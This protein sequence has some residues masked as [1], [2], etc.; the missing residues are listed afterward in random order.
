M[1]VT[2]ASSPHNSSPGGSIFTASE[3]SVSIRGILNKVLEKPKSLKKQ[4]S[5]AFL[6][7]CKVDKK[8]AETLTQAAPNV[9]A[10]TVSAHYQALLEKEVVEKE[11]LDE[12]TYIKQIDQ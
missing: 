10:D 2:G 5:G 3:T 1:Q 6:Y 11:A 12:G 7:G 8:Q 4:F 9:T